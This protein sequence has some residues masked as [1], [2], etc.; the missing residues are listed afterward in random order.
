[1]ANKQ[2]QVSAICR[3]DV[4]S[5]DIH[6]A[7]YIFLLVSHTGEYCTAFFPVEQNTCNLNPVL[8]VSSFP[9]PELDY[10]A[11]ISRTSDEL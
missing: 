2:L 6:H 9:T 7:Y 1:M 5:N 3:T 11:L 8:Q 10:A 4:A